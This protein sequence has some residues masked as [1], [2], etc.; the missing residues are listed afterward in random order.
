MSELSSHNQIH[1]N[2]HNPCFEVGLFKPCFGGFGQNDELQLIK[3]KQQREV[4]AFKFHL[5]A[6]KEEEEGGGS[7]Q[8]RGSLQHCEKPLAFCLP[9]ATF[10][11][12]G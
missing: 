5:P 6:M 8:A 3:K 9:A 4:K 11:Q 10:I 1:D 7:A 2:T 12:C